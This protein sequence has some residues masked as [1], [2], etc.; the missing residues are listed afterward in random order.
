LEKWVEK[1]HELGLSRTE[2][3]KVRERLV[4]IVLLLEIFL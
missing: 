4:F 3:M 2:A 1:W